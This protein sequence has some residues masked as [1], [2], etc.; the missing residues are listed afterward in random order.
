MKN[1]LSSDR[2]FRFNEIVFE[3]RNK[4]YGAYVLRNEEGMILK[5]SLFMGVAFFAAIALAPLVIKSLMVKETVTQPPQIIHDLTP[6]P[7]T[8]E[9][10][11]DVIK[12]AP[13]VAP[14]VNTY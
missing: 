4:N 12:P 7:Q 11:P 2:D 9:K 8:R 3:H 5:K 14:K 10:E 6:I 1:F 13:P